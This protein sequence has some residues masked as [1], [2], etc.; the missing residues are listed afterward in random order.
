MKNYFKW[1]LV[2]LVIAVLT[3]CGGGGSNNSNDDNHTK[4]LKVLDGK[5]NNVKGLSYKTCNKSAGL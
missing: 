2:S 5:F 1:F 3:A 4:N